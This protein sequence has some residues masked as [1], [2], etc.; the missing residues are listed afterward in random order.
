MAYLILSL[1][2]FGPVKTNIIHLRKNDVA[3]GY[4]EF[5]NAKVKWMLSINRLFMPDNIPSNMRTYRSIK[6]DGK[7]IEFSEGFNDLH[8]LS[9][10][11]ILTGSGFGINDARAA[12]QLTTDAQDAIILP[13]SG[14]PHPNLKKVEFV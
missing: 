3:A 1:F 13:N 6:I 10:Q 4:L 8:T 14:E 9:Y 5:S 12:I 11:K 2:L 7:E